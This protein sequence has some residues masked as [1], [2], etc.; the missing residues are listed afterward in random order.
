MDSC[1]D[2]WYKTQIGGLWAETVLFGLNCALFGGAIYVLTRVKRNKCY[3]ATSIAIFTLCTAVVIIDF[4][5]V[6]LTRITTS[7]SDVIDGTAVACSASSDE[8]GREARIANLGTM[9]VDLFFALA[10]FIADGLMIFRCYVLWGYRKRFALPMLPIL[11]AMLAAVYCDA[12]IYRL[13]GKPKTSAGLSDEWIRISNL[14]TVVAEAGYALTLATNL[15]TTI[16]IS[17]RI[18][19]VKRELEKVS[20]RKSGAVYASTLTMIIESGAI[21]SAFFLVT[22]VSYFVAPLYL[23]TSN[24]ATLQLVGIAPVL[25]IIRV[26]LGS[27]FEAKHATVHMSDGSP[28]QMLG[29]NT[30]TIHFATRGSTTQMDSETEM[31]GIGEPDVVL[32][33]FLLISKLSTPSGVHVAGGDL[34]SHKVET[35]LYGLYTLLFAGSIYV[36]VYRR[37][38]RYYLLTTTTLFALCSTFMF[39]DFVKLLETPD[40]TTNTFYAG[41]SSIS[42]PSTSPENHV[43]IR[44]TETVFTDLLV[45]IQDGLSALAQV[46]A[47][48][49]LIYRCLIIWDRKKWVVM[50]SSVCLFATTVLNLLDIYYDVEIY[51]FR[52]V[53]LRSDPSPPQLAKVQRMNSVLAEASFALGLATNTLTTVLIVIRVWLSTRELERTLGRRVGIRY[54]SAILMVVESGALYSLSLLIFLIVNVLSPTYLAIPNNAMQQLMVGSRAMAQRNSPNM[55]LAQGIAP[56]LIIVRVGMR[57]SVEVSRDIP[58]FSNVDE[59]LTPASHTGHFP[60]YPAETGTVK[61]H[62][63]TATEAASI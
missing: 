20:G 48:G 27:S 36:L 49:L 46:I 23:I 25:I 13:T 39:I 53:I 4:L 7:T 38:H 41:Y 9:L 6:V 21:L 59:L 26:G 50:P 45:T 5:R 47:H 8:R 16:L 10:L 34:D 51:R 15:I 30:T 1:G 43:N 11:L 35:F 24:G 17:W 40:F 58:R 60:V 22:F 18:F 32:G 44:L 54:R 12:T 56:T 31:Q 55:I 57:K 61:N 33:S 29:P 42:C 37:P 19:S 3:L 28:G 63:A 52:H 14:D 62:F 2:E